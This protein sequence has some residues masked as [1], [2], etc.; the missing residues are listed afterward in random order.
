MYVIPQGTKV[1][2]GNGDGKLKTF[3]TTKE[4]SFSDFVC[5]PIYYYNN[6]NNKEVM[7]KECKDPTIREKSNTVAKYALASLNDGIKYPYKF[8]YVNFNDVITY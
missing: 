7:K 2:L 1:C 5:D 6:R 8:V 3:A 4:F